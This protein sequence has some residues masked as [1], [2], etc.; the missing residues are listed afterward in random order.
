MPV[1]PLRAEHPIFRAH[2]YQGTPVL[3]VTYQH[4]SHVIGLSRSESDALL[5][6][7]FDALY[8]PAHLYRHAWCVGDLLLWD[9]RVMQHARRPFDPRATRVMRRVTVSTEEGAWF[10]ANYGDYIVSATSEIETDT[11]GSYS[12]TGANA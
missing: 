4:A 3:T 12:A 6:Q 1:H 9:N 8:A 10:E 7:L 5:S 11:L 2:P